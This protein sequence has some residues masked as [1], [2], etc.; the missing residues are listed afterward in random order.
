MRVRAWYSGSAPPDLDVLARAEAGEGQSVRLYAVEDGLEEGDWAPLV[1]SLRGKMDGLRRD[2]GSLREYC[3][4]SARQAFH[5]A[6]R[7][8]APSLGDRVRTLQ[9]LGEF[10]F[11]A[12]IAPADKK[13]AIAAALVDSASRRDAADEDVDPA[14]KLSEIWQPEGLARSVLHEPAEVAT[15]IADRLDPAHPTPITI[16]GH[17]FAGVERGV[18]KSIAQAQTV[19]YERDAEIHIVASVREALERWDSDEHTRKGPEDF[20]LFEALLT[21]EVLEVVLNE[22]EFLAPLPA[23]LVASTVDRCLRGPILA[24]AVEAFCLEW[25]STVATAPDPP[26]EPDP[27]EE[28]M[29]EEELD[30]AAQMAAGRSEAEQDQILKDMFSD[31]PEEPDAAPA[32]GDDIKVAP[33][34]ES[35]PVPRRSHRV[36]E[37]PDDIA[38]LFGEGDAEPTPA[39]DSPAAKKVVDAEADVAASA[40]AVDPERKRRYKYE[41]LPDSGGKRVLVADDS[42]MAR[43]MVCEVVNKLGHQSI[44]AMDGIEA[45]AMAHFHKPDLIVLDITMPGGNGLKALRELRQN[46]SFKQ[47]PIIMLTVESGRAHIQTA[48]RSGATEYLVKPIDLRELRK[49]VEKYLGSA[50]GE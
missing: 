20:S 28:D 49:R 35:G 9:R 31:S 12:A 13:A 19:A 15:A 26:S 21:H 37:D 44:Q 25:L 7:D 46:P 4:E 2:P 22:S 39:T 33:S 29:D 42:S 24:L 10:T 18:L 27:L 5:S 14:Q 30:E 3:S 1:R 43:H 16:I 36:E 32:P 47:T 40:A 11:D 38:D 34:S 48:I 23:H 41:R 45:V 6:L 8:F 50:P 17:T